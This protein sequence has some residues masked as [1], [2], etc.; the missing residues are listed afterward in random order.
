[1][2]ADVDVFTVYPTVSN[3]SFTVFAKADAGKSTIKM[4]N[5]RG[6]EVHRQNIDFSV[7]ERNKVEVNLSAGIYIMQIYD[8]Q[9]R[10][11]SKKVV[12]E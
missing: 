3:G 5:V 12:I 11:S 1:M 10:K 6:Q 2:I 7:E 8:A 4:Y 9:N